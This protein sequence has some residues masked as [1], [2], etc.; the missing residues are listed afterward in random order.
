M[1]RRKNR[2]TIER[3]ETFP[4]RSDGIILG[5]GAHVWDAAED[6]ETLG[7]PKLWAGSQANPV[8]CQ[9]WHCQNFVCDPRQVTR[10]W[11]FSVSASWPHVPFSWLHRS[12]KMNACWETARIIF[13]KERRCQG[14]T[15]KQERDGPFIHDEWMM[16]PGLASGPT[17][18]P[19]FILDCTLNSA[20]HL[21]SAHCLQSSGEPSSSSWGQLVCSTEEGTSAVS[22][23]L[24][25]TP[26]TFSLGLPLPSSNKTCHQTI[27]GYWHAALC[28]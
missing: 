24:I 25:I 4:L 8:V 19:T 27:H 3:H 14:S 20:F 2:K 9:L 13:L 12:P 5:H 22:I 1:R 7:E 15:S 21:L 28:F 18:C 16:V 23:F 10:P 26:L 17:L 6:N 11:W